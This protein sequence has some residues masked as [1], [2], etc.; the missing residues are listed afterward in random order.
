MEIKF[1]CLLWGSAG[2]DMGSFLDKAKNDGYDGVEMSLPR[3]E[4]EY[5]KKLPNLRI[6]LDI[7]HWC[8]VARV[9]SRNRLQKSTF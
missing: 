5:L 4:T 2:M 3:D 1:F 8:N 7:S 6:G 9:R